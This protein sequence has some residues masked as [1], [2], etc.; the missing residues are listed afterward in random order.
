MFEI[1]KPESRHHPTRLYEICYCTILKDLRYIYIYIACVF[2]C[3][4]WILG[5]PHPTWQ[6]TTLAAS[7]MIQLFC[8]ISHQRKFYVW[9][10][11]PWCQILSNQICLAIL[12]NLQN[13]ALTAS[14]EPWFVYTIFCRMV[15]WSMSKDTNNFWQK[16]SK[17]NPRQKHCSS[18][19]EEGKWWHCL[20]MKG[21]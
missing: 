1:V 17:K 10:L 9:F 14:G 12:C 21:K 16:K 6:F 15:M 2:N 5:R 7:R 11:P 19:G 18:N 3:T 20:N 13:H 8:L 4:G